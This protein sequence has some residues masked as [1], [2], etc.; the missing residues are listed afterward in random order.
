MNQRLLSLLLVVLVLPSASAH[1]EEGGG[2]DFVA[3]DNE[4][5]PETLPPERAY[6]GP[7]LEPYISFFQGVWLYGTADASPLGDQL[8]RHM[9]GVGDW[10]VWEDANRGDIYAYNIPAG[11]GLYLTSD[12]YVQRSPEIS[13]N[14]VVW[15]DYRDGWANVY[16]Y[17]LDTAETRRI[18][19]GPGNHRAPSV[20]GTLVA[21]EDERNGT[22]D[23]WGAR[24]DGTPEFPVHVG[25]DRESDPLVIDEV[26]YYRTYRFNVW[27][28]LA[29]DLRRNETREITS[30]TAINSAPFSNG[31]DVFFMTRADAGWV[32]ERYGVRRERVFETALRFQDAARQ[33]IQD[34]RLLQTV[35]DLGTNFQL[36]ARNLTTGTS[37]HLSGNLALVTEPHYQDGVAYA[38]VATR[39]GV[40]LLSLKVSEFAWGKQPKITVTSPG[41]LAPWL[42]PVTI[43]GLLTTGPGWTEPSTFTVSVDGGAPQLVA[44]GERWRTTLEPKGYEPGNHRVV[45]RATFREGPPVSALVTLVIPFPY[46]TVDVEEAGPAYH[47][48]RVLAEFNKYVGENPAAYLI[49]PLLLVILVLIAVRVWLVIRARRE[50]TLAEYVPPE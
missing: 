8:P 14:V 6:T 32:L 40:A 15:E 18:S 2:G 29:Y 48:A 20:Y 23:I 22:R 37:T 43:Q 21:W 46:D 5:D 7:G 27:D 24:L 26:V 47:A 49:I 11:N 36:V 38:A 45:I 12:P 3:P 19:M 16:A 28:V 44:P 10:L 50:H 34:D 35:R 42:R 1:G 9:R 39:D 13:G 41:T 4:P 33:S 17:F 30:D 25:P 31:K